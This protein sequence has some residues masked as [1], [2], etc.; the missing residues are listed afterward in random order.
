[1]KDFWQ[2]KSNLFVSYT[3]MSLHVPSNFGSCIKAPFSKNYYSRTADLQ[4]VKLVQNIL[5]FSLFAAVWCSKEVFSRRR[6]FE[7]GW[8]FAVTKTFGLDKVCTSTL[9]CTV[10]TSQ[11]SKVCSLYIFFLSFFLYFNSRNLTHFRVVVEKITLFFTN[12]QYGWRQHDKKLQI[13][14]TDT[15]INHIF[16]SHSQ[17]TGILIWFIFA[18]EFHGCESA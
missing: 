7:A 4:C 13:Y 11:Y 17:A 10:L 14:V 3:Y 5:M 1:M 2:Q 16:C 8:G 18:C 12:F 9:H 6:G 15:Q